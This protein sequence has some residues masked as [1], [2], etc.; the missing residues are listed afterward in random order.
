MEDRLQPRETSTQQFLWQAATKNAEILQDLRQTEY[1]G[2]ALEQSSTHLRHLDHL[3]ENCDRLIDKLEATTSKE[4]DDHIKYEKSTMRRFIYHASGKKAKFE[5]K[6]SQEKT[7]YVDARNEESQAKSRKDALVQ[8]RDI[9]RRRHAELETE[10]KRHNDLQTKLDA[11][12]DLVFDGHTPEVPG[13]DAREWAFREARDTFDA[14]KQRSET[15]SQVVKC[16]ED[17]TKFMQQV[18]QQLA[19]ALDHSMMQR[20]ALNRAQDAIIKVRAS[21]EQ[22][23]RL[24]PGAQGLGLTDAAGEHV[25]VSTSRHI[26]SVDVEL[27]L[28]CIQSDVFLGDIFGDV[29]TFENILRTQIQCEKKATKLQKL[30]GSARSRSYQCEREASEASERLESCRREL[31]QFRQEVFA[32]AAQLPSYEES[33]AF[34]QDA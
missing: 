29:A 31:R 34:P 2:P 24:S 33:I 12:Y 22:V 16:L 13:E 25:M 20:D 3:I 14:T 11:L 4:L 26:F 18:V 15:E 1:A 8:D 17:A 6:A 21:V 30:L 23:Q 7:E 28:R 27:T 5:E 19:N 32:G 9:A 10:V